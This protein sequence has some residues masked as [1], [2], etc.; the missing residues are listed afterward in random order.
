M[1][2]FMLE[3]IGFGLL[4]LFLGAGWLWLR[5]RNH[6]RYDDAQNCGDCEHFV[7]RRGV[8]YCEAHEDRPPVSAKRHPPWCPLCRP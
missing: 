1:T 5:H 6:I 7:V 3:L 8:G 4:L 2:L